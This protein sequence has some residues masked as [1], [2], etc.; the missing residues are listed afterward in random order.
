MSDDGTAVL[1]SYAEML[2]TAAVTVRHH[3]QPTPV[4]R[5]RS[6]IWVKDE[7]PQPTGSF[8]VR[9]ALCWAQTVETDVPVVTASSGNH[10]VALIW[11][12]R[13]LGHR[14][15]VTVVL[16]EDAH[17]AKA[18][19]VLASGA[20]VIIEAGGNAERDA[21][22]IRLSAE[23]GAAF[24]SSHNDRA[25]IAGQATVVGEIARQLPT[26]ELVLVPVGGGGL[27]AGS[28]LAAAAAEFDVVGVEPAGAASM[29]LGLLAGRPVPVATVD[30]CCDAL[31]APVAGEHCLAVAR[32]MSA[33]TVAVTD[34]DVGEAAQ[35]LQAELGPVELSAAVAVAG[36]RALGSTNV[37]CVVSGAGGGQRSS[38]SAPHAAVDHNCA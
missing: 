3:L 27:F 36:A 17:P 9:G 20:E 2:T 5:L 18:A 38:W 7:R 15:R 28:L 11:A 14:G 31:R 19:R 8:K 21:R 16:A 35:L 34:R 1:E 30:T 13:R 24:C 22:A 4:Y 23:R 33:R 32:A 29:A 10:A 12:L 37:V 6:G 25:V 26:A